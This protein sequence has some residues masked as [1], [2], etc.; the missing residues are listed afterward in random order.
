M[1]CEHE[2]CAKCAI[3]K[4]AR[5]L[6][7]YSEKLPRYKLNNNIVKSQVHIVRV[8]SCIFRNLGINKFRIR[9]L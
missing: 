5:A 4:G 8:R 6:K 3:T 9:F 1:P 7:G 2:L